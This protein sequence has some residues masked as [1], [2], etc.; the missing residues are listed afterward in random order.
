MASKLPSK[1]SSLL[2]LV[3]NLSPAAQVKLKQSFAA[4]HSHPAG[5]GLTPEI[6]AG[7]D[8]AFTTN[9]ALDGSVREFGR[10]AP[11]L[12]LV[13]LCSAG[14]SLCP[15]A[16]PRSMQLVGRAPVRRT[17]PSGGRS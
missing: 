13:Q 9:R 3:P 8:C 5:E 16:F 15:L 12:E 1:L 14:T 6:L 4:V 7:V 17:S 2:V 11:K 10:D